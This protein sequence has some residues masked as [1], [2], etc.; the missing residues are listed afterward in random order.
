MEA[1]QIDYKLETPLDQLPALTPFQTGTDLLQLLA[2]T[3]DLEQFRDAKARKVEWRVHSV[4]GTSAELRSVSE[5]DVA[6]KAA[7]S[8][9]RGFG[10]AEETE[11]LPRGWNLRVGQRA[12]RVASRLGDSEDTGLRLSVRG[13]DDVQAHITRRTARHLRSATDLH[14]TSY[15]SVVGV[16]GRV[17]A[18]GRQRTAALWSDLNGR[19]IEVRYGEQHV[20]DMRNAWAHAYVEVTGVLQENVSGQVLRVNMDSLRVLDRERVNLSEAL[21][22]GFYPEMTG[23]LGALEYLRLVRGED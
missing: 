10:E 11:R 19:R 17:T 18:K 1:V 15:G 9:V 23:A 8:L 21:P 12:E 22:H 2:I 5:P 16:L 3:A 14:I 13:S 6:S 7:L 4:T 20:E